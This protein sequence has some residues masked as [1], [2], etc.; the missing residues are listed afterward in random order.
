MSIQERR[1]SKG[2]SQEELAMHAGL[3]VRTIQRI[4]S[5]GKAGLESLK[6]LAAVFETNVSTLMQEHTMTDLSARNTTPEDLAEREAIRYVRR[7]KG[8]YAHLIVFLIV[9]PILA[10][11]N[12]LGMESRSDVDLPGPWVLYVF[13]GWGAGLLIHAV[14]VFGSFGLFGPEWEQR[15]FQKRMNMRR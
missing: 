2:W 10:L 4:E 12:W 7:L 3:S 14:S 6:C 9:A 13:L 8:F 15:E 5:G 11:A 1:L